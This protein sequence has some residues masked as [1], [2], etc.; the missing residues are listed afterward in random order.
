MDKANIVLT[1]DNQRG[2]Q[3]LFEYSIYLGIQV[4]CIR[5][6]SRL[7]GRSSFSPVKF[8]LTSFDR[9][10]STVILVWRRWGAICSLCSNSRSL[11]GW[12]PLLISFW[13][14][15]GT[16]RVSINVERSS[17]SSPLSW[18]CAVARRISVNSTVDS[19]S[20]GSTPAGLN[21]LLSTVL[22][23][24]RRN[25]SASLCSPRHS[26]STVDC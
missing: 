26:S 12:A 7:S 11:D 2:L 9:L 17:P 8:F 23:V 10:A 24:S 16:R 14:I 6:A 13:R 21:S 19:S 18:I 5:P 4:T 22:T 3:A 20:T 25:C 15:S 1:L